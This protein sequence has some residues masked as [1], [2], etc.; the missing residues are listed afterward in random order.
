MRLWVQSSALQGK[1]YFICKISPTLSCGQVS[2][3]YM[4][5]CLICLS[6]KS[7]DSHLKWLLTSRWQFRVWGPLRMGSLYEA[8]LFPSILY[9]HFNQN[10]LLS[11]FPFVDP[12]FHYILSIY[13]SNEA[14][15]YYQSYILN[16]I[17]SQLII[18]GAESPPLLQITR[19]LHKQ[20]SWLSLS[21]PFT[22]TLSLIH[23]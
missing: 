12:K 17:C 18:D 10:N 15:T 9:P 2:K 23:T 3:C 14:L 22:P 13:S 8:T 7:I 21:L 1:I 19:F 6:L 16:R 20:Y 4:F 5:H 11:L